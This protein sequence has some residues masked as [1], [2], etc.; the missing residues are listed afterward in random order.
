[1]TISI[2]VL[3]SY[4]GGLRRLEEKKAICTFQENGI[5]SNAK[6]LCEIQVNNENIKNIE[7]INFDFNS[8]DDINLSMTPIAK[9]LINNIQV[10]NKYNFLSDAEIYILD[11]CIMNKY[12]KKI[13]EYLRG[14]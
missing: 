12:Q 7:I 2:I 14:N 5:D 9:M 8:Q 11:H 13:I 4:E 10:T 6:Y 1:M 3:I